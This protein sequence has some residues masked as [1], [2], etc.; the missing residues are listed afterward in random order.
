[1]RRG[2][3]PHSSGL[4][5]VRYDGRTWR[6]VHGPASG[7]APYYNLLDPRVQQAMMRIV[8]ELLERYNHHPALAGVAVPL[9]SG[10]YAQLPPLEWGLDDATIARFEADTGCVLDAQ[11]P[12]RFAARHAQLTGPHADAWRTWRAARVWE[13][14]N[15]LAALVR[16][17][18]DRRRLIVTTEHS[19]D[20]PLLAARVRPLILAD[21]RVNAT[22][23]DLGIDRQRLR[24]VP[25]LSLC[26]TRFEGPTVPLRDRAIDLQINDAFEGRIR[27]TDGQ[28]GAAL[29]FHRTIR[30]PL[31]SVAQKGSFEFLDDPVLASQ[32]LPHGA[33]VRQPYAE[34]LAARDFATIVD[35]GERL[36]LGQEDLLRPV[37]LIIQHL[38]DRAH[39]AELVRQPI[40]VRTYSEPTRTTLLMINACPWQTEAK[41]QLDVPYTAVVEPLVSPARDNSPGAV[42]SQPMPAGRQPWSVSLGPYE[43][44]AVRIAAG[45]VH[46]ADVQAQVSPAAMS[47]LARGISELSNRDTDPRVSPSLSNPSFEPLEGGPLPGWQL[48]GKVGA[49]TAELDATAP[50]DGSTCLY[51]R[52][53]GHVAVLES[54]SFP[55]P[56]TGQ[57]AATVFV[58]AQNVAPQTELR[59]VLEADGL[60]YG[61]RSVA[62]GGPDPHAYPLTDQ[63][64]AYPILVND[65]PLKSDGQMRIKFQLSGPGE[66]WLDEVKTYD[67]LFP[68]SFYKYSQSERLRIIT[69]IQAAQID[70]D[71]GKITDCLRRLD[72]YW[73]RFYASYTPPITAPVAEPQRR[74]P[75][76]RLATP[77]EPKEKP[78]PGFSEKIKWIVPFWR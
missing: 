9:A 70:Y 60:N 54:N 56:A 6:E 32:P 75:A 39:Q 57:L 61:S 50:H 59:M 16:A 17:G 37:R 14:Y 20:H 29:F 43:I 77:A 12:N 78:A 23:M 41:L 19:L 22:M 36:P 67:L 69:E 55:T 38:P 65:L 33:F 24:Q 25:G 76:E 72:G 15:R 7:Q 40:F 51:F 3:H 30:L 26:E 28:P 34:A 49:A 10:G 62:I 68:L 31:D 73:P 13:F 48:T 53:A 18:S 52:S 1:L 66:I 2:S 11:G 71:E 45:G 47:E 44:Q 64:R 46:V 74:K 5:W 42:A 8:A 27:Q 58:R 63:W 35:G 4:E 21:N